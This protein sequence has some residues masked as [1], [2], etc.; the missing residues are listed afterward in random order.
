MRA[1]EQ[2]GEAARVD[3]PDVTAGLGG[4][5]IFDRVREAPEERAEARLTSER[6]VST[7]RK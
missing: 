3:R 5:S 4:P 6:L 2:L 7:W 1:C